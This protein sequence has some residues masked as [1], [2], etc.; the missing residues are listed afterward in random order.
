M[1]LSEIPFAGLGSAVTR[2]LWGAGAQRRRPTTSCAWAVAI[3][4]GT[5][6]RRA[7]EADD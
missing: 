4:C 3:M 7:G 5:G 6:R 1:R 2:V